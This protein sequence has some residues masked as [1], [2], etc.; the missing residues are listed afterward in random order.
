MKDLFNEN[1][2][3]LKKEIEEYIRK[4]KD[5][6]CLWIS[7]INIVKMILLPKAIHMFNAI[8]TKILITFSTEIE[9]SIPKFVWK[10]KG[11]E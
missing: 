10:H 7:R 4:W 2:K 5:H 1:Y 11:P 6:P 9:K 3:S 8:L